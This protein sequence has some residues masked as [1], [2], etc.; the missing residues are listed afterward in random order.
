MVE[1]T[2]NICCN[3]P[4]ICMEGLLRRNEEYVSFPSH[5]HKWIYMETTYARPRESG[6]RVY[7]YKRVD[8]FFCETCLEQNEVKREEHL[9]SRPD[10]YPE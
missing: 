10:W 3:A 4:C 7:C 1:K 2:C 5:Q 6:N 9:D 8:R